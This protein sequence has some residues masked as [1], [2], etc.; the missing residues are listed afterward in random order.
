MLDDAEI[1]FPFLIL[2]LSL[3]DKEPIDG[4]VHSDIVIQ[5]HSI[6]EGDIA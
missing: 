3:I 4:K 1:A 5:E 2:M 6:D